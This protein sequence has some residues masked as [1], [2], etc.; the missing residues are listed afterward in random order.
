VFG[1][2]SSKLSSL[3]PSLSLVKVEGSADIEIHYLPKSRWS[4]IGMDSP[5]MGEVS[6]YTQTSFDGE[7]IL[8][9]VV[10][11]DDSLTQLGRNRTLV[12]ELVHA[13][14]L[15]HNSCQ[16]SLM[17][18]KTGYDPNWALSRY[19]ATI[20]SAWYSSDPGSALESLPC[21][22]VQWDSVNVLDAGLDS[23]IWCS[24]SSTECYTVSPKTGLDP[25]AQPSWWRTD[26]GLS[27]NDPSR[28]V[29][30]DFKSILLVC[31]LPRPLAPFGPCAFQSGGSAPYWYDG[32]VIYTY[33]P[34]KFKAFAVDGR[35]LLCELPSATRP[36]APCQFT[37]GS[38]VVSVEMY[39]D[40][41]AVYKTPPGS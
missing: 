35:R 24:R 7:T 11:I 1:E 30:L 31:E 15:G 5:D 13:L 3:A 8:S 40:G 22:A 18:G 9:A 6:G 16:G 27:R 37:E 26:G 19:D 2:A 21:P 10:V 14:G 25:S 34:T 33:D 36:Y 41:K 23:A 4:E 17:Y 12:H 20:F 29:Q 28:Y 39:T 32:S 38:T